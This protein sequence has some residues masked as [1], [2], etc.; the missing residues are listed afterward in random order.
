MLTAIAHATYSET[1]NASD[2]TIMRQEADKFLAAM[3]AGLQNS[4]C[5]A[6]R[7]A[8]DGDNSALNEVRHSRNSR[9]E[10]SEG[11]K[12][13]DFTITGADNHEIPVRLFVPAQNNDK[14]D[15]P[16]LIYFHGG[17]WTFGS[18]NSCSRF[19]DA[20]AATGC[21]AVMAV[22]YRLAPEHPFPEGLNDCI[23]AMN[24]AFSHSDKLGISPSMISLGGDSSGGNLALATA[25]YNNDNDRLPIRSIVAFY[26]VTRVDNKPSESWVAYGEG[27]GLDS[28]LM[29][30]FND[31]YM[32]AGIE[33]TNAE[34]ISPLLADDN[35]LRQ[36]PETLMINAERDIL[37]DQGAEFAS[38]V[39]SAGGDIH[40]VVLPGTVHLFITVNGQPTAF[41][42]SVEM[43]AAFLRP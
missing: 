15:L 11:V 7:L 42:K 20:I 5:K 2:S 30:A 1:K 29:D 3:P 31:A 14:P 4:Q 35:Q 21:A 28:Q 34:Y 10:T 8:I 36:M 37:H 12:I 22:E 41:T 27:F 39:K 25:L 33:N 24:F 9:P 19:C 18:I 40:R 6:V 13:T 38:R 17:G 26:P 23:S 32:H 43:T 16:L